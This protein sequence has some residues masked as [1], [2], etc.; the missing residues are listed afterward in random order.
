MAN[1]KLPWYYNSGWSCFENLYGAILPATDD[2]R[3]PEPAQQITVLRRP[4]VISAPL[5]VLAVR[6]Y[7]PPMYECTTTRPKPV[8]IQQEPSQPYEIFPP[9]H[10]R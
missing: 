6:V 3:R 7:R 8:P 2:K 4:N 10:T 9:L 1:G 5:R